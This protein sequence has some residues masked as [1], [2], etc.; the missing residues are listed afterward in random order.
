MKI[1]KLTILLMTI[2]IAFKAPIVV[3]IFGMTYCVI[4]VVVSCAVVGVSLKKIFGFKVRS[5]WGGIFFMQA[6]AVF[7]PVIV[8]FVLIFRKGK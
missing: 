2:A 1:V 3:N 6:V 7:W 8:P 4:Y 5:K